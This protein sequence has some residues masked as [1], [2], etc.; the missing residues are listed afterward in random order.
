MIATCG[1]SAK[2]NPATTTLRSQ[3][4]GAL[5]LVAMCH[6]PSLLIGLSLSLRLGL[7][8]AFPPHA[9]VIWAHVAQERR[10]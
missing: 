10:D 5:D 6:V 4:H 9:A 8:L 7:G 2:L 3:K 1:G